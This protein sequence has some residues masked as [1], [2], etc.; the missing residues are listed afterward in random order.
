MRYICVRESLSFSLSFPEILAFFAID[1]LSFDRLLDVDDDVD[2]PAI[3]V[4]GNNG[5][6]FGFGRL[7]KLPSVDCMTSPLLATMGDVAVTGAENIFS[8]P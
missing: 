4:D 6:F 8:F 3:R 5:L 2:G 1:R 7:K